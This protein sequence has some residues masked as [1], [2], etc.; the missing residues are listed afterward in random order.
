MRSRGFSLIEIVVGMALIAL[1]FSLTIPAYR[2]N[3]RTRAAQSA[4]RAVGF[5]IRERKERAVAL[6][7]DAGLCLGPNNILRLYE[8][9]PFFPRLFA[10]V[11]IMDLNRSFSF[12]VSMTMGSGSSPPPVNACN[13]GEVVVRLTSDPVPTR[14]WEGVLLF[15]AGAQ[16]WRL[17]ARDGELSD[18]R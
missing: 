14:D 13:A 7:V 1:V 6:G 9:H 5:A 12:P 4:A 11:K 3:S 10:M 2:K 16:Q 8:T 15:K 17:I 18:G